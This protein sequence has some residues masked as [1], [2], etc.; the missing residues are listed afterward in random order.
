MD[1]KRIPELYFQYD[2]SF[3]YGDKIDRL[4]KQAGGGSTE[5]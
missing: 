5:G 4:L 1:M 2:S 3:D